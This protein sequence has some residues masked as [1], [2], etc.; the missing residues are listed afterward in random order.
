MA[1][2]PELQQIDVMLDAMGWQYVNNVLPAR[3]SPVLEV[4]SLPG[5]GYGLGY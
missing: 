2:Y 4:S 3:L 5:D 1:D